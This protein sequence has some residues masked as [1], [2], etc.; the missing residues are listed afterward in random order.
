MAAMFKFRLKGLR[1][2]GPLTFFYFCLFQKVR[3]SFNL[4]EEIL[5]RIE[6]GKNITTAL[7]SILNLVKLLSLVVK[8]CKL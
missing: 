7:K 6:I 2:I 8:C 5:K 4:L 1:S 3:W